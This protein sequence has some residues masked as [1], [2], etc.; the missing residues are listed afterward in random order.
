MVNYARA[1]W[2]KAKT[3][4]ITHPKRKS[5]ILKNFDSTWGQFSLIC[6]RAKMVVK[7]VVEIPDT[8]IT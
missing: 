7:W 2:S 1:A 5:K 6:S 8:G 3:L 4:I